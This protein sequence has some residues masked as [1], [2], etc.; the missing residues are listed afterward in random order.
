MVR[1]ALLALLWLV[2][3]PMAAVTLRGAVAASFAPVARE[4][5]ERFREVTGHEVAWSAG[6]TG[7][8]YAQ[9]VQEAPFDLFLA[10]DV[11]R[12]RRL[13]AGGRIVAG[14]RATYARGRLALWAPGRAASPSLLRDPR[15]RLALANPDV[16][17]YGAAARDLLEAEGVWDPSAPRFVRGDDV[18][19]T[20]AFV[21]AGAVDAGLVALSSVRRLELPG[22]EV[23]VVPRERHGPLEQQGV[24]LSRGQ[25][26]ESLSFLAFL[27]SAE[28]RRVIR[29]AGFDL[30]E[31]PVAQGSG[32]GR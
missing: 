16:A 29:Q 19:Q 10:A 31:E 1:I 8:L 6:S 12:P 32:D 2:P 26:A 17:P 11:E 22:G 9:I 15:I 13:E 21:R 7:K 30:P 4:L 23:W 14:S 25:I 3:G 28:A 24:V 20:S 27:R 18:G 5:G